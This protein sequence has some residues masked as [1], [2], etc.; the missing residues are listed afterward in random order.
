M[1][2][3][4]LKLGLLIALAFGQIAPSGAYETDANGKILWR[5]FDGKTGADGKIGAGSRADSLPFDSNGKII[6]SGGAY[7]AYA[8]DFNTSVPLTA[9]TTLAKELSSKI[10]YTLP[11][12]KSIVSK[13]LLSSDDTTNFKI[14]AGKKLDVWVTFFSEGAGFENSVGFFT[15]D[16]G[17]LPTRSGYLNTLR[18]E[19]ILF[20]RVSTPTPLPEATDKKGTTAYIGTV[21]GTGYTSGIGLGFFLAANGWS[22]SGRTLANGNT[23]SGANERMSKDWIFYS[24]KNLN[25][26]ASTINQHMLLLQD[27]RVTGTDGRAYQRMVFT[28][29][30][31]KRDTGGDNDFN[32]VVMVVHVSPHDPADTLES[33]IT[34]LGNFPTLDSSNSDYD[35]DGVKDSVDEFPRDADKAYSL[36]YPSSTTWG[37]LAYED[38]WPKM[39]DYDLNDLVVRYRSRQILNAQRDVKALEM[40]LRVDGHGAGMSNGFAVSLPGIPPNQVQSATLT[41]DGVAV[42]ETVLLNGVTAGN[43]GAVFQIFTDTVNL[44]GTNGSTCP[45][46]NSVKNCPIL[47]PVPFKLSIELKT[48]LPSSIFPLAPYDPFLFN[49]AAGSARQYGVE[50][51]LPGKQPSSRA[52][53]SLFGKTDDRSVPN[54]TTGIY[55]NSYR[56]ANGLPWAFDIPTT[57]DYPFEGNDVRSA[58]PRIESWATTGGASDA[59]WYATPASPAQTFRNGR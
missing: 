9:P 43:G 13:N 53:A 39:G 35:G 37:T 29:E 27:E 12:S 54:S 51:H 8:T 44:P 40:D 33:V 15:Y 28:F 21:D 2:T 32:D 19:Q 24:L 23:G 11:E 34:N 4:K 10:S 49:T 20:P 38:Q 47:S 7:P 57:W 14:A 42:P 16:L 46:Q 18:S 48:A 22:Y 36:W 30:D 31:L 50:V 25:P 55:A 26:E 1:T 41:R 45:Y 59:N 6:T 5:Y 3:K 17:N 52:D 58:Y 56:T